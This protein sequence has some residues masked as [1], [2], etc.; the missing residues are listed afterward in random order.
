MTAKA[1]DTL[2]WEGNVTLD[3]KCDPTITASQCANFEEGADIVVE[4]TCLKKDSW[5]P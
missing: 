5:N 3:W 4:I 2:L 1:A